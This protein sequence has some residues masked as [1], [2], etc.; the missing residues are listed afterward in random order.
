MAASK[1]G[2]G[3]VV[4][5]YVELE[6]E[7]GAG[8]LRGAVLSAGLTAGDEQGALLE[9][10]EALEDAVRD[11]LEGKKKIEAAKVLKAIR[12]RLKL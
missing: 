4:T 8:E 10:E 6:R 11:R 12:G 3:E 9:I 5:T 1:V 2:V 7:A